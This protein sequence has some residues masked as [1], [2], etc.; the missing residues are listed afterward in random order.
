M[1]HLINWVKNLN[2]NPL[3]SGRFQIRLAGRV[4]FCQPYVKVLV[5]KLTVV[6]TQSPSFWIHKINIFKIRK[7]QKPQ[8]F[9]YQYIKVLLLNTLIRYCLLLK[10][11]KRVNIL[12][13]FI[14]GEPL[15]LKVKVRLIDSYNNLYKNTNL[16]NNLTFPV[17]II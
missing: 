12:I 11:L 8:N 7:H 3:I 13:I 5:V 9:F 14:N 15:Y 16:D 17:D 1:T 2:P 10:C 6:F 4:S